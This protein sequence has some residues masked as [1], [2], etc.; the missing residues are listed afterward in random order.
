LVIFKD[1]TLNMLHGYLIKLLRG[2]S[3]VRARADSP[4]N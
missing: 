2:L 3:S 4:L 1:E